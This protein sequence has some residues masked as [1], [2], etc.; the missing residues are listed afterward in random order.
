MK[1]DDYSNMYFCIDINEC[2]GFDGC[3]HICENLPG[4][5]RC[6]C[7]EGYIIGADERECEGVHV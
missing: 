4:T 5:Y 1:I 6:L 2:S 7:P 3:S